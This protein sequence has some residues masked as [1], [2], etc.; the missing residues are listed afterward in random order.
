[1]IVV[2]DEGAAR[3]GAC[4]RHVVSKAATHFAMGM[5]QPCYVSYVQ[6]SGGIIPGAADP[7]AYTANLCKCVSLN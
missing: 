6:A 5:C 3:S 7:P 4:C 1:M 2:A